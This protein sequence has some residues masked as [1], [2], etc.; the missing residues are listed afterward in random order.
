MSKTNQLKNILKEIYQ[1]NVCGKDPEK[2]ERKAD[3]INVDADVMIIAEA[4]APS[5]VRLSG[6][7]YFHPDGKIGNT[8][9][10]LEKFLS[11]LGYTVYPNKQNTIYHSEIVHSFP[12]YKSVSG[13]KV[14]RRPTK[15]E[16]IKSIEAG[17]LEKE[18][19]LVKPRL[20]FLMGSTSYTSFYKYF[21][22]IKKFPNLTS[23][24]EE[25]TKTRKYDSYLGIPVVP[26]QHASGANPRFHQMIKNDNLISLVKNILADL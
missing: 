16:I 12:G 1:L 6:I 23:K 18:I 7:N 5:Q 14:I 8:G 24:I 26:I 20:I 13:K 21:L 2:V 15:A 17:V 19:K 25:I 9:R 22:N 10:Y 4:I 3:S 11:K